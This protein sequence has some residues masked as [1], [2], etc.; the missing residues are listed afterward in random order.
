MACEPNQES[1][2]SVELKINGQDV[3][4]NDFVE[5]FVAQTILGMVKS[6]RGVSDVETIDLKVAK[7][8]Q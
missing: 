1:T 8:S 3:E 6:L 4:L 2:V 5:D 7:K